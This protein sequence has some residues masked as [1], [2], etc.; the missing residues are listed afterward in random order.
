MNDE[1][2][3][4]VDAVGVTPVE[5]KVL[6]GYRI[7]IRFNDGAEGELD[8]VEYAAKPWFKPWR[9]RSVFEK[10]RISP[11][12]ALIWGSDPDE[13][14]MCICVLSLYM[15]LTGKSWDDLD[16]QD[17]TQLAYA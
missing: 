6:K 11:Y 4:D 5:V 2:D 12:D 17:S 10:V 3:M 15:Q 8:L 9:D 7:W 13:S 14:D 16:R 1:N